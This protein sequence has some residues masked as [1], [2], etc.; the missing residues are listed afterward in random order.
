MEAH[1][2]ETSLSEM[3]SVEVQRFLI[4][5][6][7]TRIAS[8]LA[9]IV[10]SHGGEAVLARSAKEA[11]TLLEET[12]K[13]AGFLIDVGLPDGSGLEVLARARA[14]YPGTPALILTGSVEREHINTAFDLNAHYVVKP[15]EKEHL[16]RFFRDTASFNARLE[17]TAK[18]WSTRFGLSASEID[19]LVRAANGQHREA[20]AKARESSKLTIK[21]HVANLL[22]KTNDSSLLVAAQKLLREAAESN[23]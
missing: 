6:D 16:E 3:D 1:E 18:L 2:G 22:H 21:K 13:W 9:R 19:I 7:T 10:R 14:N 5:E 4:V 17:R 23:E 8:Y 20:I 15:P 11:D 12:G